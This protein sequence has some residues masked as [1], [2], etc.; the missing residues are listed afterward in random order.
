MNSLLPDKPPDWFV[1][2]EPVIER[3]L[4]A[5]GGLSTEQ[6]IWLWMGVALAIVLVCA[7]IVFLLVKLV[8]TLNLCLQ[9]ESGWKPIR[10]STCMWAG[11]GLYLV[12]SSLQSRLEGSPGWS[13]LLAV[14]AV[15]FGLFA[16][17]LLR[18]LAPL[19]AA[20]ALAAN[21]VFGVILAPIVIDLGIVAI[22]LVIVL[23][24]WLAR[25]TQLVYVLNR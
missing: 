13:V 6:R 25:R 24:G 1:R 22:I 19:R 16:W 8:K 11:S 15:V 10:F 2:L 14:G 18:R 3:A 20:G 4:A 7:G 17:F 9:S 5:Y 23:I 12:F 21:S